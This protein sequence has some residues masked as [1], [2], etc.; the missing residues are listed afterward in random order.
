MMKK[1][2]QQS[3]NQPTIRLEKK[4]NASALTGSFAILASLFRPYPI[5]HPYSK[6]VFFWKTYHWWRA[7]MT[8][9]PSITHTYQLSGPEGSIPRT[10]SA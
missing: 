9:S 5:T 8:N 2:I 10:W 4:D 1:A 3:T 7:P 6:H